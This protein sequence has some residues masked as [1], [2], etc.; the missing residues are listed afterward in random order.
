V[1]QILL[2]IYLLLPIA[3]NA[4]SDKPMTR[5]ADKQQTNS[6]AGRGGGWFL[7][8]HDLLLRNQ[9]VNCENYKNAGNA[10]MYRTCRNSTMNAHDFL[11]DRARVSLLPVVGWSF[12]SDNIQYDFPL[13]AQCLTAVELLCPL[14]NEKEFAD[15]RSCYSLMESNAWLSNPMI[16]RM[17]FTKPNR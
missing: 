14:N 16:Q 10:A 6:L 11:A 12:C 13:G 8:V 17:S 3:A 7:S 4:A 2:I 9:L 1:R 5:P 15:F